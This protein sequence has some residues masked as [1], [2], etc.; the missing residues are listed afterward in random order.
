MEE[1][2]SPR[3]AKMCQ[4]VPRCAKMYQEPSVQGNAVTLGGGRPPL[5]RRKDEKRMSLLCLIDLDRRIE[6]NLKQLHGSLSMFLAIAA[7]VGGNVFLSFCPHLIAGAN[8]L[9]WLVLPYNL[10]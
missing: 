7:V 4:D 10:N 8:S 1:A 3:V 5:E 2:R 9:Y 6:Y